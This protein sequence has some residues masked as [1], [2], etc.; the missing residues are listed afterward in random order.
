MLCGRLCMKEERHLFE[1][2]RKLRELMASPELIVAPG[3]YDCITARAIARSGFPA[4]YMTGAGTAATLGYPD[5]GLVTM[6]EMADNAGRI[7][8]TIDLPVI[9]DADTG[10]GNELNVTRTVREY[11]RRGVAALHIEDQ[12]F[13][14]KCGHLENKALI[15]LNAYVQKIRAAA[16][17]RHNR[18]FVLIARTDA[19]ATLG[20]D[21]AVRRAN[22]ALEAGADVAF[23]EAPQDMAEV[24]AVPK[25][26]K[27]PCLLNLVWR[28][29]TPEV[30]F[31]DAA[32]MGYRL[33]IMPGLLVKTVYGI[34]DEVLAQTRSLGR[35]SVPPGDINVRDAFRRVGADE[36]DQISLQFGSASDRPAR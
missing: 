12:D 32:A 24:A 5:Y 17:A 35:H 34:C 4:C 2:T 36:W 8:A 3:A 27:G 20:L 9:A 7:A 6:S 28:G 14:K 22:A 1:G 30:P 26:V 19:R 29:K 16:A 21:E 18:D 23:V 13:P 33:A 11:E 25:R 31:A 15:P 10:Y